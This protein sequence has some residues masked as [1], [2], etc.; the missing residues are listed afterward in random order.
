MFVRKLEILLRLEVILKIPR[1]ELVSFAFLGEF[2]NIFCSFL[3]ET[4][5]DEPPHHDSSKKIFKTTQ[6]TDSFTS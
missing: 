5:P 2:L 6:K 3:L 1:F 4:V